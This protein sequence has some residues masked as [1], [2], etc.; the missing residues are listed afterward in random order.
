[1]N[2]VNRSVFNIDV[3][4]DGVHWQ[5]KYRFETAETFQYPTF[6]EYR[7]KIYLTVTQGQ[8]ERIMFGLLE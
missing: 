8:K 6:R 5:R 3:S 2:G 4:K 7:G 1:M